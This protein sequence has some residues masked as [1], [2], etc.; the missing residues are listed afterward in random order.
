MSDLV[1]PKLNSDQA[2]LAIWPELEWFQ[3][4]VI[5]YFAIGDLN[6]GQTSPTRQPLPISPAIV[7]E[8]RPSN[9]QSLLS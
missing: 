9:G 8:A 1:W 4:K 3:D 7:Q 6:S 5:P 2:T